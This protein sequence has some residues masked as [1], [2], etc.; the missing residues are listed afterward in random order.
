MIKKKNHMLTSN[1]YAQFWKQM[2]MS[3]H[4]L[5]SA[6]DTEKGRIHMAFLQAQ[7]LDPKEITDYKRATFEFN[8]RDVHPT[9]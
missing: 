7:V 5:L 8:T 9:N 2:S 4:R 1:T 3:Q 6:F